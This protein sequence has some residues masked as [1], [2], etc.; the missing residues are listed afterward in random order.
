MRRLW[1]SKVGTKKGKLQKKYVEGEGIEK[2]QKELLSEVKVTEVIANITDIKGPKELVGEED[3][4]ND[5]E[6]TSAQ[7]DDQQ[8]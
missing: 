4:D 1:A 7:D 2:A 5:S 8:S 3:D 6:P